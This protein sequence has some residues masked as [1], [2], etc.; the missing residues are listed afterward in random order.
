MIHQ[1]ETHM[2]TPT[3]YADSQIRLIKLKAEIAKLEAE[4]AEAQKWSRIATVT[5]FA[6]LVIALISMI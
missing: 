1:T 3:Q 4:E 5:A 6:A 2:T